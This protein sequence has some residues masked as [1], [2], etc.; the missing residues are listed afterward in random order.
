MSEVYHPDGRPTGPARPFPGWD[1]ET[2]PTTRWWQW[3]A[4]DGSTTAATGT[5]HT[6]L[7]AY[8]SALLFA[9][10]ASR[11]RPTR[12]PAHLQITYRS[13]ARL[14]TSIDAHTIRAGFPLPRTALVRRRLHPTPEPERKATL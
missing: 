14:L 11:H 6:R 9:A 10:T 4:C 12:E 5:A 7:G 2:A 3:H 13:G 1:F 8:L